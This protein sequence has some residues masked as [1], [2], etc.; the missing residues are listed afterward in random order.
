MNEVSFGK[1]TKTSRRNVLMKKTGEQLY[2]ER[3]KRIMD[4]IS[5]N[6]PDRVPVFTSHGR[7][8]QEH[9][10]LTMEEEMMD[11]EKALESSYQAALYFDADVGDYAMDFGPVLRVCSG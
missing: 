8:A 2:E 11:L 10:G 3:E 4:A 1:F 5:L 7:F 9:M 6:T